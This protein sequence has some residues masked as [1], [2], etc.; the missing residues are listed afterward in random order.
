[1][2]I[3]N[4]LTVQIGLLVHFTQRKLVCQLILALIVIRFLAAFVKVMQ[5]P[6]QAYSSKLVIRTCFYPMV[7]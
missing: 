3:I 4:V 1:M 5:F 6:T 2:P 7:I